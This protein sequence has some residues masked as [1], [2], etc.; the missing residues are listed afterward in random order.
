MESLKEKQAHRIIVAGIGPG[1]PDY[2]VPAARRAIERAKYL[3]GGRRA[4]AQFAKTSGVQDTAAE[5]QTSC[6]AQA[7]EEATQKTCAVTRDIDGVLSFVRDGL[8]EADVVVMVSGDPGYFSLLDALRRTFDESLIDVIPGISSFQ[9]A[10]ARLALPWHDADLLSFHGRVPDDAALRYAPGRKLGLLTDQQHNSQT[11]AETLLAHGWPADARYAI[12]ARLSYEDETVERMTLGE[13]A[14]HEPVGSCIVVISSAPLSEGGGPEGR[15][16][17]PARQNNPHAVS[18][19]GATPSPALGIPDNEFQRGDVP[20]TKEEVRILTIAKA[21][22]AP[23]A[24][25]YD[26]GAGT[27]SLTI[28]AALQAPQGKVFAIERNSEAVRLIHANAVHFGVA[29]R[30]HV[31]E[32]EAPDGM[33]DLPPCDT[34]LIGGSGSHLADILALVDT[35]LRKGGRI[36]LNF[37]TVQTLTASIEW[38]RAHR[39]A[40]TYET[41]HVQVNRLRQVGPYDMAKAEN[42]IYIVTAEKKS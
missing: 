36:V 12:C 27:G 25:V 29:D 40:Y 26:V 14:K 33:A 20:M 5:R 37:I 39:G 7:C 11:I 2:L 16:V 6:S 13:A 19:A 23:D 42:P 24:I 15:G 4:L 28:E 21:R 10:F 17:S 38:L 35:K 32:A 3:I 18:S 41:I 9:L 8:A 34:V 30:V 1:S 31:V 22:I